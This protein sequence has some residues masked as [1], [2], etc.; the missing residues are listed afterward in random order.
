MVKDDRYFKTLFKYLRKRSAVDYVC[1]AC[2]AFV[3]TLF[4]VCVIEIQSF[5]ILYHKTIIKY[6]GI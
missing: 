5:C 6:Y 3:P 4:V 2:L 1:V